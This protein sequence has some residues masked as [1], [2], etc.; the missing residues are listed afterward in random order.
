MRSSNG[1]RRRPQA[2]TVD[3][4]WTDPIAADA[5]SA[6]VMSSKGESVHTDSHFLSQLDD[7][8]LRADVRQYPTNP[9]LARPPGRRG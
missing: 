6:A 4:V 2:I 3:E 9:N 1:G 5:V 8:K 7:G